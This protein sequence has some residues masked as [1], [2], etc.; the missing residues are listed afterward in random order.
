MSH[1]G[2]IKKIGCMLTQG[3]LLTEKLLSYYIAEY[4][5]LEKLGF[6]ASPIWLGLQRPREIITL[7]QIEATVYGKR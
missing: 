2:V 3:I 4:K 1:V 6:P 5:A 7:Y